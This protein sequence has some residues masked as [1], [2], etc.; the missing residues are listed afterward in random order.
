MIK[1]DFCSTQYIK[2]VTSIE[3]SVDDALIAPFIAITQDTVLQ[4]ALGS[5]YF[6]ELQTQISNNTLTATN[7]ALIRD[8]IQPVVAHFTFWNV[9]PHVQYSVTNKSVVTRT[10]D[11]S[12]KSILDEL[13]YFRN[14]VR[15]VAE[16]YLKRLNRE[17]QI[18]L[19]LYPTYASQSSL[20]NVKRNRRS[21]FGGIYLKKSGDDCTWGEDRPQK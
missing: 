4:E 3:E 18:N 6:N 16:Y 12:D 15:D 13:K 2:D 21:F 17:L 1:V 10:A 5:A 19:T 11:N 7:E 20:Q 9:I 14:G 8:Y